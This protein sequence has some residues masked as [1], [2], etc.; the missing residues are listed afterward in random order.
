M[1]DPKKLLG[2]SNFLFSFSFVIFKDSSSQPNFTLGCR[3]VQ[4]H[5]KAF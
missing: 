3:E 4:K 1:A 2:Y 5:A